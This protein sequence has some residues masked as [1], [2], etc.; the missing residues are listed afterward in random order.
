LVKWLD[1]LTGQVLELPEE[2]TPGMLARKR[3]ELVKEEVVVEKVKEEE[4]VNSPSVSEQSPPKTKG[5]RGNKL[6][7]ELHES[8]SGLPE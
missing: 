7:S 1:L 4:D 8:D 5:R 2:S 3:Y 6:H